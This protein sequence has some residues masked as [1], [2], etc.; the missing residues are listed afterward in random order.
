MKAVNGYVDIIKHNNAIAALFYA[1][2]DLYRYF[3]KTYHLPI[4]C[5]D[6]LLGVYSFHSTGVNYTINSLAQFTSYNLI[7]TR[8]YYNI[9]EKEGFVSGYSLTPK[10][11]SI[12]NDMVTR[13]QN[14]SL[15]G[16]RNWQYEDMRKREKISKDAKRAK[17]RE[18]KGK[19]PKELGFE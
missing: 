2:R 5:I 11:L 6:L 19:K 12:C 10:G 1:Y 7:Q 9:I 15:E 8:F 18:L 13:L 4:K 14:V 16:V 17:K 3:T